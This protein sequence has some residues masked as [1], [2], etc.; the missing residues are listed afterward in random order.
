MDRT[1]SRSAGAR[2]RARC[3]GLF[4]ELIEQSGRGDEESLGRLVDLLQPLV[5]AAARRRFPEPPADEVAVEPFVQ[6]WRPAP[7]YDRRRE[8]AITWVLRQVADLHQPAATRV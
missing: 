5:L 6:V 8:G 1:R 3:R 7:T 2:R 4:T